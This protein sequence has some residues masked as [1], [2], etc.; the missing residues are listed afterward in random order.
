VQTASVKDMDED[1]RK[2]F[3]ANYPHH[4]EVPSG[5]LADILDA[6]DAALFPGRLG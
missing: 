4:R 3:E 1:R 6:D 5:L 2:T